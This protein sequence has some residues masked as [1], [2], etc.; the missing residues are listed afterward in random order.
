MVNKARLVERI[1]QLH[2]EKKIEGITY[3]NRRI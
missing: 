3:L 2:H 1:S